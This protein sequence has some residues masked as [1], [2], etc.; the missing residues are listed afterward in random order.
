[1]SWSPFSSQLLIKEK[2]LGVKL[3]SLGQYT[4]IDN[5]KKP[6]IHNLRVDN[7]LFKE[8]KTSKRT[9][10]NSSFFFSRC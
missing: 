3:L 1:M 8:G 5:F 10:L 7:I 4:S 9:D 6:A 2:Y